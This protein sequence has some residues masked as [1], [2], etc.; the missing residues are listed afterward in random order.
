MA[1]TSFARWC[2]CVGAHAGPLNPGGWW[3]AAIVSVAG[4]GEGLCFLVSKRVRRTGCRCA[5]RPRAGGR[6]GF[7]ALTRVPLL[8]AHGVRKSVEDAFSLGGN[9]C[10]A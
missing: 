7:H 6:A 9:L 10:E 3:L 5:S 2:E 4:G 8:A 1:A